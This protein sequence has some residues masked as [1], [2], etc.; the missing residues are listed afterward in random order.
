MDANKALERIQMLLLRTEDNGASTAEEDSAARMV[1][2]L[3]RQF[4]EI[5]GGMPSTQRRPKVS[6]V[7]N[8]KTHPDVAA[9]RFD[10][11]LAWNENDVDIIIK[12]L[13]YSFDL[14]QVKV[15]TRVVVMPRSLAKEKG[16]IDS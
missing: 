4:P 14:R 6:D 12:G 9:I 7:F 16:L 11:V 1:C 8:E 10:R 13:V 5:I 15:K 2:K 3:L